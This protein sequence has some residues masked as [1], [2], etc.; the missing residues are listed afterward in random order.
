[1]ETQFEW[2]GSRTSGYVSQRPESVKSMV[3]HFSAT[4]NAPGGVRLRKSAVWHGVS[5][6]S[7]KI[8]AEPLSR[9]HQLRKMHRSVGG[10]GGWTELH[11][12]LPP[13]TLITR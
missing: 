12:S 7:P 5:H 6:N 9:T 4:K 2:D 13:G 10:M 3:S 1:V 11:L 8:L